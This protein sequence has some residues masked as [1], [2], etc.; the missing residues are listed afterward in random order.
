MQISFAVTAYAKIRFSHNEAQ[1]VQL[2][3][4]HR[5]CHNEIVQPILSTQ[6]EETPRNRNHKMSRVVR[7]PAFCICE[8]KGADQLRGDREADQRLCFR[9]TD[10]TIPLIINSKISSLQPSTMAVQPGLCG[11]RSKPPKTGFLT[12]R[13]K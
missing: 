10:S 2:H 8:N 3:G 11:T 4:R 9:Y 6:E 12:T 1:I 13:L 7:K 5:E